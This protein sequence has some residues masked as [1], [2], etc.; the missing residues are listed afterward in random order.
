MGKSVAQL[1]KLMTK[2][3]IPGRGNPKL[4]RSD[5]VKLL[6]QHGIR[7]T[8]GSPSPKRGRPRK[9]S[10]R[11][12]GKRTSCPPCKDG[13]GCNPKTKRCISKKGQTWKKL[14]PGDK[15]KRGRPKGAKNK[16]KRTP[17]PKKDRQSKDQKKEQLIAP[18]SSQELAGGEF[19]NIAREQLSYVGMELSDGPYTAK[20]F[21]EDLVNIARD[22][23]Y[24]PTPNQLLELGIQLYGDKNKAFQ[25]LQGSGFQPGMYETIKDALKGQRGK[26]LQARLEQIQAQAADDRSLS[27]SQLGRSS[28]R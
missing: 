9:K 18:V 25:W 11:K 27:L 24:V 20:E 22:L 3:K 6:N 4:R 26:A 23:Q 28:S 10:P 14:H 13:Y 12:K 16:R 8:T 17:K 7:T 5:M 2:H 19:M 15:K 21:S 1:R